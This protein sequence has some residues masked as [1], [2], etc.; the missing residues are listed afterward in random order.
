MARPFLS[1]GA[2]E[3]GISY[4]LLPFRFA[5]LDG[6]RELITTDWGHWLIAEGGPA[7]RC[8]SRQVSRDTD[9]YRTLRAKQ[10]V[11]DDYGDPLL[12][13]AATKLRTKKDFL[14]RGPSLHMFV[15]T[16][17]CEHTCAYC[18]VSRQT[19]SRTRYD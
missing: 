4:R 5:A 9:L 3:R 13:V 6:T 10:I 17:R 19:T 1:A 14:S 16:L 15:V 18:Q 7:G 11:Y 8:V 12:D 2:F